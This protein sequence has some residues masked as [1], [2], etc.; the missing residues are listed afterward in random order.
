MRERPGPFQYARKTSM[1][2]VFL[3]T[4]M[5]LYAPILVLI[6]F[7]FNDAGR[8]GGNVV[9]KGFSTKF[10]EK[11]FTNDQLIEAFVNSL[12]IAVISTVVATLLG[13]MTAMVL[14]R[15]RFPLKPVYEGLIALPIVIPEI[16]MGVALAVFFA[17]SGLSIPSDSVWPLSLG[18]IIIAHIT[19]SFPFAAM[20]IRTRL[21]SFNPE[22]A[23]AARDLG[24]TEYQVFKDILVPHMVPGL[25]AGALL[26]F[27]LSL[28]DFVIT[29]FTSGPNNVTFP[30]KVYSMVRFSVTPEINAAS[31]ILVLVTI[32]VTAVAMRFQKPD[33]AAG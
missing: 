7:S 1:R 21:Q 29:F 32:V 3:A 2:L 9:W 23:E 14:W 10:Y 22:V 16:C 17:T 12:A 19:F 5:F 20:V 24:A 11:A 15:W 31:T 28:D 8:R 6:I 18:N 13:A 25:V 33:S 30:V 26:A 27:T 4:F